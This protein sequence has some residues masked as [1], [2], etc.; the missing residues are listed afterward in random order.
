MIEIHDPFAD[1]VAGSFSPK[2]KSEY[3]G[4][5]RGEYRNSNTTGKSYDDRVE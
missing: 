5:L 4:N 3:V 2:R 1:K